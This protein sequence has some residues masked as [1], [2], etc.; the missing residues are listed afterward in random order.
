MIE[1]PESPAHNPML[2]A[3]L[4]PME[5]RWLTLSPVIRGALWMLFGG[6]LFS[7]MGVLVK[8]LGQRL[9]S[10]Q[11]AFFRAG[12]GFACILPF[13]L[14]AG[15]RNLRTRR[16]P[17][18]LL[19]GMLGMIA[20]FGGFYSVV[21]LPLADATALSF[22]RPLFVVVLAVII[23]REK[24]RIRRWS[25]TVAGFIGVLIMLR[26]GAGTV[27]PAALVGIGAA[28]AV[29]GVVIMVKDLTR[30]EQP[31]AILFYFGLVSTVIALL[32]A[33][34]FWQQPTW[35][36]FG[37]LIAIGALG[38]AGQGATVRSYLCGEATLVA[39]FDYIRLIYSGVLGWL[40]FAELPDGWTWIGAAIIVASTLYIAYREA[41]LSRQKRG[42]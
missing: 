10:F 21:Y 38:A 9:D 40:F 24:V 39:P 26:P 30:T 25:A 19:R 22:T 31:I 20:M 1:P 2:P 7:I 4:I 27:E 37:L 15:T 42:G 41:E 14:A 29:A 34:W 12:F 33:I 6:L 32:P 13:A 23:L 3:F 16:L 8:F 11:I 35:W 18:H 5:R 36:E 17:A 28:F